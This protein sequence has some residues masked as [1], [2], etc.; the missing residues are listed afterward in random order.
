[1]KRN[2]FQLMLAGL[3]C[4]G[5]MLPPGAFADQP[6]QTGMQFF[7]VALRDGGLLVGVVVDEAGTRQA[8][9][10][11]SIQFGG[12]EI[13]R[14]T[15]DENGVFAA[16]GLRGGQYMVVSEAGQ[17]PCR[18]WAPN[19]APPSAQ[20]AVVL[21][22]GTDLVRGQFHGGYGGYYGGVWNWML[23]HP[24]LTASIIAAAIAIP[25]A[26]SDDDWND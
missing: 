8:G 10:E 14:T 13:V 6:E 16:Q 11:V 22:T 4:M 19:T 12:Q 7:D 24:Y 1:M 3:A 2:S 17:L 23:N 5:M 25:I 21:L 20:E 9:T 15:A 18:L 26:V